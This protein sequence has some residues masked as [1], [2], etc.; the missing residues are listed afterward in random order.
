MDDMR[1]AWWCLIVGVLL[2]TMTAGRH[3]IARLPVSASMFYLALGFGLGP[4]GAGLMDIDPL[5]HAGT[6]ERLT[7]V[8]VL[9]SLFVAGFK[10]GQPAHDGRW[11][12]PV[13]LASVAMVVTVALIAAAA[14]FLLGLPLGAAVL[15]GAILAPTDPVLASDVQ[16]GHPGDRDALRFAL[17]GEGALNDGTAFPFVMLGLGLLG[18]HELGANGVRWWAVDVVWA[19]SGALA[20]G[21]LLGALAGRLVVALGRRTHGDSIAFEFVALGVVALAY[22]AALLAH[23]YGFLAVFAAGFALRREGHP[24]QTGPTDGHRVSPQDGLRSVLHFNEQVERFAEIAVVMVVGALLGSVAFR[25]EVLWFVP[26]VLLVIR[27]VAVA[28]GTVG[29]RSGTL[30]RTMRAWFG[31]R[32]IGSIYYLMYAVTRGVDEGTSAR[33]TSLTLAVVVASVVLHGISVTPLM[34]WYERRAGGRR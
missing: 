10:L 33:L 20:G 28:V 27:P 15:L 1:F 14:F 2:V 25:A 32:G 12:V 8:A 4:A 9:I 29:T 31:I 30:R 3:W 6:L 5:G 34:A 17:T 26:L 18:L 24:A 7:E 11:R 13:R 22:G 19:V 21:A 23:T 16:L